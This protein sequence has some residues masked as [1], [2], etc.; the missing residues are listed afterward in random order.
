M[1]I[2]FTTARDFVETKINRNISLIDLL[3]FETI[4]LQ[5]SILINYRMVENN[6]KNIELIEK[7]NK[8]ESEQTQTYCPIREDMIKNLTEQV[9]NNSPNIKNL[10]E[11]IIEIKT[12]CLDL[13]VKIDEL[14]KQIPDQQLITNYKMYI[15]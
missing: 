14:N 5:K 7:I 1:N 13:L 6:N 10:C 12:K 4:I 2:N 3:S 15:K 8:I 9:N 11:E